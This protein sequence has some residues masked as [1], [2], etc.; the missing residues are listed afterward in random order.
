M[1]AWKLVLLNFWNS[2][3]SKVI[4]V[5]CQLYR[6][7]FCLFSFSYI[8]LNYV[9]NSSLTPPIFFLHSE[10]SNNLLFL[11]P[12]FTVFYNLNLDFMLW[13]PFCHTFFSSLVSPFSS[14]FHNCAL[15]K[16]KHP[17]QRPIYQKAEQSVSP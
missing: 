7:S 13:I 15:T 12:I 10:W 6:Y 2:L 14:L 9:C 3:I 4:Q 11:S 1:F 17:T 16:G 8:F 5:I